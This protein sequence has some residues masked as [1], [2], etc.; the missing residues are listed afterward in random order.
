MG[1]QARAAPAGPPGRAPVV[2]QATR[3]LEEEQGIRGSLE[4]PCGWLRKF[5]ELGW[6]ES[7]GDMMQ[8]RFSEVRLPP[9]SAV[10]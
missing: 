10:A 4:V 6:I 3:T 5:A 2:G 1:C 7:Q 8:M 9:A